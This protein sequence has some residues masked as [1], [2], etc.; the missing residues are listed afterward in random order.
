MVGI[1]GQG[2]A[3]LAQLL[4]AE[5][6]NITGSDIA[7]VFSTDA[8][9]RACGIPVLPFH[10]KNISRAIDLVIRSGAYGDAHPEL[11]AAR[12]AGIPIVAYGDAV[13]ELFNV[14][15]GILVAGTHGKTT[16]TAMIGR[17]L[18]DA[19]YDPA[20]LVGATVVKW[21]LNA[22]PGTGAWMVAEGDEYQNKFLSL[23][24]E[25]LVVTSIE[26]D[27]PD[28]FK[29]DKQYRDAF[30]KL[31]S[32]VPKN[33]LLIAERGLRSIIKKAPCKIV[34]YG[35][36]GTGEGRHMELNGKAALAVA[37]RLGI[38]AKDAKRTL[39][40]YEGTARRM[41][42]YT[43]P[44]A[45][46]AV[47]DDYA[48]HPTEIRTTLAALRRRYPKRHITAVFHPHTYSRTHALMNDFAKSFAHADEVLLLPIY[49]SARER[50]EDF[51]AHLEETLA[52]KITRFSKKPARVV[53][54]LEAAAQLGSSLPP[55]KQKRIFITLGAGNAWEIA[56]DVSTS[57]K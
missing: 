8:G 31:I 54:S 1:K 22:R 26:Y 29:S 36:Q 40:R 41:E 11:V 10:A 23:K 45:D 30:R 50:P 44:D 39:A 35:I 43:E 18:E 48:H 15:R 38:S 53:S 37:R 42:Y 3:A 52:K 24:P 4:S 13:A 17:V 20:V 21:K 27:H 9:L 32:T 28:F 7:E 57:L 47:I 51:P 5:G 33:G 6:K 16:T 46:L 25:V 56:R 2:M 19:G 55:I 34:W 49:S 14:K 12:K